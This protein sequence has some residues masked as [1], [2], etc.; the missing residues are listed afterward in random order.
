MSRSRPNDLSAG[1]FAVVLAAAV[2]GCDGPAKPGPAVAESRP[3]AQ[4]VPVHV[5]RVEVGSAPRVVRA[6]GS[7]EAEDVVTIGAKVAGRIVQ[8]GPEVGDR[9]EHGA[10]LAKVEDVDY[11]LSRDQRARALEE[12]L[13]KLGLKELPTGDVELEQLPAVERARFEALNAKSKYDRG[14]PL[15]ARTPPL[16]SDQDLA[17]LKVAWDVA[18]SGR[19][20]AMLTARTDLAQARTRKTE[21][22]AADQRIRDTVHAAPDRSAVWLVGE[23]MVSPGTYVVVG[24]PL[25]RLVDADP[26]RLRVRVPERKMTGVL[27]GKPVSV[28]VNDSATPIEAKV[29]RLRPEVD[30]RTR[31]H[32]VEIEVPNPA[33]ALSVG[34]FAVGEIH[35]GE[36][37]NVLLVD[38][39][40]IVVF[41]GI[42]KVFV[43]DKGKAGERLV[44]TGRRLGGRVEIAEGLAAGE[45]YIVDPPPTLVPGAPITI[46]S[47]PA[48]NGSR[49]RQGADAEA[50]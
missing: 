39:K 37:V 19:K 31:T 44:V 41:A 32:E 21:I 8:V 23:R 5:Q 26:L 27:P 10:I 14:L 35:V 38:E 9:V 1:F 7:F 18:E 45:L 4:A 49:E 33:L 3:A 24:A 12:S 16:I 6:M 43:P 25:Y 48:E 22:D 40:A 13:A 50:R 46:Q 34:A 11:V 36:D 20:G 29:T 2:A 15:H 30:T 17:D 28:M 47:G 42:R